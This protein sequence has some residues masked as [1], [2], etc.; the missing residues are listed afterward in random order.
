MET[1]TLDSSNINE[2]FIDVL[3]SQP[4]FLQKLNKSIDEQYNTIY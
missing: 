2:E 3:F 1:N 4:Y